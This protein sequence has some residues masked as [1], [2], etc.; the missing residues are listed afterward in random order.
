MPI[1]S[2]AGHTYLTAVNRQYGCCAK[3]ICAE[4]MNAQNRV[5]FEN[6]AKN[7]RFFFVRLGVWEDVN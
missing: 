6:M 3:A 7:V 1:L 2:D 5:I 4:A